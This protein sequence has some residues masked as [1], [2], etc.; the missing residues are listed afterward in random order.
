MVNYINC[1][2]VN[3]SIKMTDIHISNKLNHYMKI[4]KR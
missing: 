3:I 2:G 1:V 4:S